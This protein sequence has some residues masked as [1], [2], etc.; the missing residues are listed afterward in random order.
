MIMALGLQEKGAMMLFR[1]ISAVASLILPALLSPEAAAQQ[2]PA[3]GLVLEKV[4]MMVRHGL[5]A[6]LEHE[7]PVGDMAREPWPQ[8]PV[9]QS[10]MTERG[11]EG[12]R[13][14][15]AYDRQAYAQRGLFAADGCP[16]SGAVRIRAS[17]SPRAIA[18]AGAMAQGFAPGCALEVQHG[19]P[20]TRDPIFDPRGAGL[21]RY[22]G[23]AAV[24]SINAH[25]GGIKAL[26]ERH[27]DAFRTLETVLGCRDEDIADPCDIL[28]EE[29]VLAVSPDDPTSFVFEGP[30]QTASG[31]AQVFLLQYAEGFPGSKVGW[32]RANAAAIEHMGVLHSLLFDVHVRSPYMAAR[33]SAVL[34]RRVLASLADPSGA[35]LDLV[36]GHDNNVNGLAA[37]LDVAFK[38]DGYAPM[39]ASV[40]GALVFELLREPGSDR[41]YVQVFYQ[42][43]TLEQLRTLTPL[44][45]DN[46]PAY[47]PL[48]MPACEAEGV[49]ARGGLCALERF[50]EIMISRLAPLDGPDAS[51][52]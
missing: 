40:G 50:S 1:T 14:L 18:S 31:T 32:G 20:G 22:D 29:S 33:Q 46:P 48:P 5:R 16:E 11:L 39:D 6:P 28:A 51:T 26:A 21:V 10:M 4:V 25:T 7:A 3:D 2:P 24:A 15:G 36:V 17:T 52:K 42:A 19:A 13:L 35:K 34:G 12:M 23:A 47:L 49:A 43:Q 27:R 8:W 38:V 44:S 9:E 45:A 37:V 41:R 30:I